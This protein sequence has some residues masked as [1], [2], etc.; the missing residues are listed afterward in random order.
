MKPNETQKAFRDRRKMEAEIEKARAKGRVVWDSA[1]LR[2]Y[3][4]KKHEGSDA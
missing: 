4:R 3:E 1:T 2:T